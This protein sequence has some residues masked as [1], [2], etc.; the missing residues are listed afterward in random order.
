MLTIVFA[1]IQGIDKYIIE[2]TEEA[3]ADRVTYPRPL[4]VIEGPLMH[5]SHLAH[6]VLGQQLTIVYINW[7]PTAQR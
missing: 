3:R 6:P 4:N 7:D 5:V 1:A 2:D